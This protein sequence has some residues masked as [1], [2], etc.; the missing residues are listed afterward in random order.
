MWMTCSLGQTFGN[1]DYSCTGSVT[2]FDTWTEALLA[3]QTF[4]DGGG[5]AGHGDWRVPNVKELSSLVERACSAPSIVQADSAL[6]V[7]TSG[8]SVDINQLFPSTPLWRYWTSTN[9]LREFTPLQPGE[10][11]R[12]TNLSLPESVWHVEFENGGVVSNTDKTPFSGLHVRLVRDV[13]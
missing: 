13:E 1:S 9:A 7:T 2:T 6:S 5:Y 4:N 8:G 3:V 10:P 11:N 12:A